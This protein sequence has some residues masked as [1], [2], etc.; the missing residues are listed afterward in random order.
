VTTTLAEDELATGARPAN[1]I[2]EVLPWVGMLG[3][4]ALLVG[5]LTAVFWANIVDLPSYSIGPDGSAS[6]SERALTEF[7]AADAW[8][9]ICGALV[10]TGLGI[11]TWKWFKPLGW[12]SALL[13]AAA[14]LLAGIVCWQ[15][16]ELL[17]PAGGTFDER[18]ANALPGEQVP[19]ALTL[20]S[21]SAPAVWAF[22]AVTP[23]LLAAS[24]GPEE[25]PLKPRRELQS[26][27]DAMEE[28]VDER[29]VLTEVTYQ[30]SP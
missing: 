16:G 25:V 26:P 22:A 17:G 2:T 23:I 28:T 11:V 21:L 27:S 10:G 20:R 15:L 24:L 8:Y 6:V 1:P 7:V 12:P 13:A 9:V 14:G 4:L 3:L 18:L 30:D 5:A 19:I 29:G